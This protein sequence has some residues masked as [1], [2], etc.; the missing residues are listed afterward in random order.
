MVTVHESMLTSIQD[1]IELRRDFLGASVAQ[2]KRATPLAP[3]RADAAVIA[4]A[5]RSTARWAACRCGPRSAG[6]A[7]RASMIAA[8]AFLCRHNPSTS[9]S[10]S[11]AGLGLAAGLV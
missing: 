2:T 8:W 4:A 9:R 7:R 3:A 6:W 10:A 5:R 1:G 11:V